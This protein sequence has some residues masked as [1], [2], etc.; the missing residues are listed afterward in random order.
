MAAPEPNRFDSLPTEIRYQ[1]MEELLTLEKIHGR[2]VRHLPKRRWPHKFSFQ[3][4]I[5]PQILRVSKSMHAPGTVVLDRSSKWVVLDM[6]CANLLI[7]W[8]VGVM[9]MIIVDPECALNLPSGVLNIRIKPYAKG[10][11]YANCQN[12]CWPAAMPDRQIILMPA[13]HLENL[14]RAI[15]IVE[16]ANGVRAMP[17]Q[18]YRNVV[19]NKDCVALPGMHGMSICVHVNQ[20]YPS[21]D[22]CRSLEHLR[23]LHG[24]LNEVSIIGA[25][26][27]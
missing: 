19:T 27:E 11:R 8:A 14:L 15:R 2:I 24:P 22:I 10:S 26:D 12:S 1:I 17:G 9:D 3:P 20:D 6:D 23:I 21:V 25:P 18:I 5:Q 13:S 16:F 4:S 7:G